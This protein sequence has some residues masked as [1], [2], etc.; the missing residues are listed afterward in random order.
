MLGLQGAF[1]IDSGLWVPL[2]YQ[3]AVQLGP[4]GG[5]PLG[6]MT[7]LL[8]EA[9]C[10]SL[11]GHRRALKLG[12]FTPR[13]RKQ[14]SHLLVVIAPRRNSPAIGLGNSGPPHTT[15]PHAQNSLP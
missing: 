7:P 12:I 13:S 11:G 3:R 5:A 15:S 2:T 14:R 10:P 8:L 6:Q 9:K 4:R 1:L